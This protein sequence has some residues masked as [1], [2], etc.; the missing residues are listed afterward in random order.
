LQHLL[1]KPVA[2]II[3]PLF[4][5]ANTDIVLTGDW[6]QGLATSNSLGIFAGLFIGKPLGITLFS[7]LA[8]KSGL[9]K[10]PNGIFWKYMIGT[11]FLGGIGFTMSIFI[12]ILAFDSPEFIQNSKITVL[13]SSFL[14]G[15]TGFMI[16]KY[17]IGIEEKIT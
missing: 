14:S 15:A 8:V 7:F 5:L 17:L 1:H 16:L 13:L 10:L 9:S 3:M 11:G 12:T 4:A 2:F 6:I